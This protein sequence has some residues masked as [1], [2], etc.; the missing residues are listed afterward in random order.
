[1]PH[2]GNNALALSCSV[3]RIC[4]LRRRVQTAKPAP[5][6]EARVKPWKRSHPGFYVHSLGRKPPWM[7][8]P[9]HGERR[10][11]EW[12]R[13]FPRRRRILVSWRQ[14]RPVRSSEGWEV[15]VDNA[16]GESNVAR[17][18]RRLPLKAARLLEQLRRRGAGITT[19][20]EPSHVRPYGSRPR[21]L[22]NDRFCKHGYWNVVPYAAVKGWHKLQVS[23]I[24][25]VPQRDRR[26]H[27][28]VDYSFSDLNAETLQITPTEPMQFGRAL[29]RVLRRIVEAD[30]RYGPVHLAK[31]DLGTIQGYTEAGHGFAH[32]SG[33][34]AT[35][36]V[37]THSSSHGVGGVASLFH[38][39]DG[40]RVRLGELT[41]PT[42][43]GVRHTSLARGHRGNS[44]NGRS[45]CS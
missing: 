35:N 29:H 40:D 7:W 41:S 45:H 36:R 9:H 30:A 33:R 15:V 1:M 16:R 28:I 27:L 17:Q 12:R 37:S 4:R 21:H 32:I 26:P 25:A 39:V 42:E 3:V 13:R 6:V 10:R 34:T 5:D 20:A 38:R 14:K 2:P 19:V 23:P 18:V 31:I 43:S 22:R 8:N 44:A 24:G 11:S